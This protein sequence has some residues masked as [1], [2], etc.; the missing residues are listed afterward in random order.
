MKKLVAS[1]SQICVDKARL[2]RYNEDIR[3][4]RCLYRNEEGRVAKV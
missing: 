2:Q 1:G 4:Y 3:S